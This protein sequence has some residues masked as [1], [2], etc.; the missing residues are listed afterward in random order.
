MLP[1]LRTL[2]PSEMR[3]EAAVSVRVR[4]SVTDRE[5]SCC[6]VVVLSEDISVARSWAKPTVT[7]FDTLTPSVPD[8]T[9]KLYEPLSVFAVV[10]ARARLR[11]VPVDT[12]VP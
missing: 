11:D 6:A 9:A 3:P 4:E 12:D 8:S 10:S 2:M 7:S 5:C 1:V